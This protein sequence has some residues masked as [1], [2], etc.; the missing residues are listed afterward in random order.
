MNETSQDTLAKILAFPIRIFSGLIKHPKILIILV[1]VIVVLVSLNNCA[2]K[3]DQ[4]QQA[5]MP[6][7]QRV[8]PKV[9]DA[10]FRVQTAS[11]TYYVKSFEDF[12][13]ILTLYEYYT[14][15]NKKWEKQD[16]NLPLD[17]K[18]Y[19]DIRVYERKN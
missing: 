15:D 1:I 4:A 7:Y 9:K 8:A 18:Y 2:K 17:R 16:F 19:G 12:G 13:G 11:R 3:A 10:P 5:E 6:E 14:Y